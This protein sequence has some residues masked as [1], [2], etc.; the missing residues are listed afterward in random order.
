M[1]F[2]SHFIKRRHLWLGGGLACYIVF[3]LLTWGPVIVISGESYSFIEKKAIEKN[4]FVSPV[5]I[6]DSY[7]LEIPFI[8]ILA[9]TKNNN[10]NLR[11]DFLSSVNTDD[12]TYKL[13]VNNIYLD[14]IAGIKLDLLEYCTKEGEV[15]NL[16]EY[17][18]IKNNS[19]YMQID[20]SK[21]I[22]SG[23]ILRIA[24]ICK[25][26]NGSKINF[27]YEYEIKASP[28]RVKISLRILEGMP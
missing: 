5:F 3:S 19:E 23:D 4:S 14:K 7:E 25:L 11:I 17:N 15:L 26:K 10:K 27:N 9:W 2:L 13:K 22:V 8:I 6:G 12:I 28:L 24:G 21:K 20:F 1:M 18:N 16:L